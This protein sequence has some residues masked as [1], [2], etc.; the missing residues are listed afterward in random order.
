MKITL[1]Q[2]EK[3]KELYQELVQKAWESAAFKE[4]LISNPEKTIS[5]IIG[6]NPSSNARILVEDQTDSNIIYLNIPRKFDANEI[7]LTDE[8]LETVAG[9][10]V[11]TAAAI[12]AGIAVCTLLGAAFAFGYSIGKDIATK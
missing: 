10:D 8:Q 5:E 7:E 6:V 4:Q 2:Q 1:E 9:G 12:T 3:G 11:I